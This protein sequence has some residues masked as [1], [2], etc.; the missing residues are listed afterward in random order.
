MGY[1]HK[2]PLPRQTSFTTA[3]QLQQEVRRDPISPAEIAIPRYTFRMFRNKPEDA[4]A[5]YSRNIFRCEGL[6]D[7]RNDHSQKSLIHLVLL[8]A[9]S[10]FPVSC[11]LFIF[12][13]QLQ[14]ECFNVCLYMHND[15]AGLA[16]GVFLSHKNGHLEWDLSRVEVFPPKASFQKSSLATEYS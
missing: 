2:W 14:I 8:F 12:A 1:H 7:N 6:Q 5:L 11:Q 13:S 4:A 3:S 9:I 15:W 16:S 10:L